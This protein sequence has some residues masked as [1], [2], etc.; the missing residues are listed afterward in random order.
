VIVGIAVGAIVGDAVG[1]GDAVGA[2]VGVTVGLGLGVGGVNVAPLAVV[3]IV[4]PLGTNTWADAIIGLHAR[5]TANAIG[6][7]LLSFI[8]ISFSWNI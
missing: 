7:S 8:G 3:V 1:F 5:K 4:L 6:S 2:T